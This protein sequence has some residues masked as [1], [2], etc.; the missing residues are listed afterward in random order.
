MGRYIDE[1]YGFDTVGG[2]QGFSSSPGNS[3]TVHRVISALDNDG[4]VASL[5]LG[6]GATAPVVGEYVDETNPRD[7]L[8]STI[9]YSIDD[10]MMSVD[11]AYYEGYDKKEIVGTDE[12]DWHLVDERFKRMA[13]ARF[14]VLKNMKKRQAITIDVVS[15]DSHGM[16]LFGESKTMINLPSYDYNGVGFGDISRQLSSFNLFWIDKEKVIVCFDKNGNISLAINRGSL[17]SEFRGMIEFEI[18]DASVNIERT[19]LTKRV[20]I[21]EYAD[22]ILYVNLPDGAMIDNVLDEDFEDIAEILVNNAKYPIDI[23]GVSIK[24]EDRF[25][26]NKTSRNIRIFMDDGRT[27]ERTM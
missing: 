4:G 16:V 18:L 25:A 11:D 26:I 19:I 14:T 13:A 24:N 9:V 23:D 22:D 17:S 12:I 2:V 5:Y 7:D 20:L 27:N 3:N 8:L 6:V 21:S 10:A 1:H 15:S